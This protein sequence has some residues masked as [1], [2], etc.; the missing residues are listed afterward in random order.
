[1][2]RIF[3][4]YIS[5]LLVTAVGLTACQ[6]DF[7]TQLNR[8]GDFNTVNKNLLQVLDQD[9]DADLFLQAVETAGLSEVLTGSQEV[10]LFVPTNAA[11]QRTVESLGFKKVSEVP[12]N[13]LAALLQYHIVDGNVTS[14][15]LSTT[16]VATRLPG[17]DIGVVVSNGTVF[18]NGESRVVNADNEATNGVVHIIDLTLDSP[19][20]N[21][22]D[23]LVDAL[24]GSGFS[25]LNAL[26]D[27]ADLSGF[28]ASTD[29]L[30]VFAPTDDAFAAAGIDADAIASLS[31]EVAASILQYHVLNGYIYS[32]QVS[33]GRVFTLQGSEGEARGITISAGNNVI[34]NPNGGPNSSIVNFNVVATNGVVH[35]INQVLFPEPYI[36]EAA[37]A[38]A[39]VADGFDFV[40]E[41]Y[42]NVLAAATEEYNSLLS[43]EEEYTVLAPFGGNINP[44]EATQAE[45]DSFAAAHVFEGIIELDEIA[46]GNKITSLGGEEYFVTQNSLGTYINGAVTTTR[47]NSGGNVVKDAPV[48]NGIISSMGSPLPPLPESDV[49]A[50]LA[51][52]DSLTIFSAMLARAELAGGEGV[53]VFAVPNSI[54]LDVL[55]A[56][57]GTTFDAATWVSI[58]GTSTSEDVQEVVT[59]ITSDLVVSDVAFAVDIDA[60]FPTLTTASANEL[61]FIVDDEGN[62]VIARV[63]EQDGVPFEA[64]INFT[65]SDIP[66][67]NGVVHVIDDIF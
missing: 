55:N 49:I 15:Q 10:T 36:Y 12:A 2:K 51:G 38:Q 61:S 56:S 32:V 62:V 18:L 48:Y 5:F 52:I 59:E 13:A 30:T 35:V 20:V 50:T 33:S 28:L 22:I 66:G 65:Q 67:N 1:M 60:D 42:G 45:I 29:G 54:M 3:I 7:E 34:L 24:D 43:S 19:P 40:F 64:N 11:L 31:P 25:L 26:V 57:F 23:A 6:E 21:S 27:Q 9:L 44:A 8:T 41:S 53:T 4:K 37:T 63:L 46:S 39:E 16:Q 14:G 17:S 58:V 47:F